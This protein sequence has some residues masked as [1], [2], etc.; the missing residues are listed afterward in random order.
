MFSLGVEL[1]PLKQPFQQV[2]EV[3][4]IHKVGSQIYNIWQTKPDIW[5]QNDP[6][7]M[8]KILFSMVLA[9]SPTKIGPEEVDRKLI[10]AK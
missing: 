8:S 7:K 5:S 4:M 6:L 1:P 3:Q 2:S 10:G 9:S